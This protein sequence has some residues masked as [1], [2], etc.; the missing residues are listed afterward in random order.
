MMF[1]IDRKSLKNLHELYEG[2]KI[3]DQ[4]ESY[5]F[6]ITETDGYDNDER[7][8]TQKMK[9]KNTGRNKHSRKNSYNYG[10]GP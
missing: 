6:E 1:E 10:A 8:N 7:M 9:I 5:N 4:N 3:Q 2:N